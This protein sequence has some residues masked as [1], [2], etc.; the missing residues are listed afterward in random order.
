MIYFLLLLLVNLP[1]TF[2][3]VIIILFFT[4]HTWGSYVHLSFTVL[5]PNTWLTEKNVS[6]IF[7]HHPVT[8]DLLFSITSLSSNIYASNC[9]QETNLYEPGHHI[10][11]LINVS[12]VTA[13]PVITLTH[14]DTKYLHNYAVDVLIKLL[15]SYKFSEFLEVLYHLAN[16]VW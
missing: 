13:V 11:H 8:S 3:T 2:H 5:S 15:P 12:P 16:H 10:G 1:V 4:P 7:W 14:V 9:R 6:M